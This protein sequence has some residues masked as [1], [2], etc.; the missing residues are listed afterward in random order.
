M[1]WNSWAEFIALGGY[2]FYVWG[3]YGGVLVCMLAE[4]LMA[5]RRHQKALQSVQVLAHEETQD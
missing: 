2:G 5:W 1:S 4:P 3:A